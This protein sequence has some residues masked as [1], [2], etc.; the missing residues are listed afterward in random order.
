MASLSKET[1]RDSWK[2]SWY[3]STN[4]RK[5]I[6]LGSMP[7]KSAES[8]RVK[9]EKLLEVRRAGDSLPQATTDWLDSI[10]GD[11]RDRIVKAG[12]LEPNRRLT[13]GKFCQEFLDSR[14]DVAPATA[15]R[16]RQVTELL[17]ERF[18]AERRLD[19]ISVRDAEDWRRWLASNGNKRD[20]ERAELC[21][22]TVRRRTGVARQIFAT[23]IRWK[24]L[25][26]NPFDGLATTVRENLERRVFVSWADIRRVI[27]V[28]PGLNGKH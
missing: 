28:A 3:D 11:L 1:G 22:N 10:D 5:A 9:F 8:F 14:S 25:S 2:L 19:T 21:D 13:L 24:L 18:G 17:L 7:K 20:K 26:F 6:R 23:A 15:V 27:E 12:L 4:K 16:D